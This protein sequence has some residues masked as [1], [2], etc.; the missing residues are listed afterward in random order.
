M[1]L[2]SDAAQGN[3]APEIPENTPT[4]PGIWTWCLEG[5]R[6]GLYMLPRTGHYQPAPWQMA[7]IA[8]LLMLFNGILWRLEINGP[9]TFNLRGWLAPWWG[10]AALLLLAWWVLP[11]TSQD[12]ASGKPELSGLASWF[13]LMNLASVPFGM[14]VCANYV[15]QTR[16]KVVVD[17]YVQWALYVLLWV[18]FAAVII[19]LTRRYGVD[20]WRLAFFAMC[21]VLLTVLTVWQFN[22]RPWWPDD[23]QT[24]GEERPRLILNQEAFEKQQQVWTR[25]VFGLAKERP[26][27]TDVY[28]LV[29]APYASE[30][31]FMRE[32]QMVAGVLGE[33][34]DAQHR[35]L[36]LVNHATTLDTHPWA[37]LLNMERAI[38][39]VGKR[40]DRKRDVLVVYLTSH[41]ASNFKLSASHW[42]LKVEPLS[43]EILR[44]MLDRAGIRNRVIAVSACFS[45]GWIGPLADENT[46]IMTAAH[47]DRTSYGCGRKSE[48]T[49][50]GR[51]VFDEQLRKT[52]S[53]EQA[54]QAARPV[55]EEREKQAGKTDGYS[56][57]Q[58][59]I[60]SE[61]KPVLQALEQRLARHTGMVAMALP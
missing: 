2:T 10:A 53:F 26:G 12:D 27:V 20:R 9:A 52:H 33:R 46:L 23:S 28:G 43:P 5:F 15:L 17:D 44:S 55:I 29:F 6:A 39:A 7:I 42:P 37:T 3:A 58:I 45:G 4:Q 1:Q 13:A 22:D 56:D 50:F 24:V 38:Q 61:I 16:T 19:V 40:M 49:Y 31:V 18:L 36:Q 57:P 35:I 30:D 60:G 41:G 54:F 59:R 14:L 25:A 11:R 48:L 51:A 32:S 21:W 8:L 34:F 47:A